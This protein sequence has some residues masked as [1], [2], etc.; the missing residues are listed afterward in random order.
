MGLPCGF[1][2]LFDTTSRIIEYN[3]FIYPRIIEGFCDFI[4]KMGWMSGIPY[5]KELIFSLSVSVALYIHKYY[6]DYLSKNAKG[7]LNIIYKEEES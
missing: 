1:T 2:C 6:K 4:K 5:G 7:L 3:L